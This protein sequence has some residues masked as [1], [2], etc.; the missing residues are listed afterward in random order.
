MKVLYFYAKFDSQILSSYCSSVA[1]NTF[2]GPCTCRG[3][4]VCHYKK[5]AQISDSAKSASDAFDARLKKIKDQIK[6]EKQRERHRRALHKTN[7][8]IDI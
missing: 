4:C 6:K 5:A 2:D 3:L 7:T 1:S 8:F